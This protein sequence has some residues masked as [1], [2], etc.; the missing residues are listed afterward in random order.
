MTDQD[1]RSRT[2]GFREG[3]RQ[4]LEV[5]S[6]FKDAIEDTIREARDRGDLSSERAKEIMQDAMERAQMAAD[7]AKERFDFVNR[8]ELEAFRTQLAALENRVAKLEGD[9]AGGG[10]AGAGSAETGDAGEE[11]HSYP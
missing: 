8:R 9:E 4:G 7:D 3:I 1:R 6:A 10:T 2:E 5:L 11:G